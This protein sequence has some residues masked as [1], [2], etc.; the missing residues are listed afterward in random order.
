MIMSS[1]QV[2][3]KVQCSRSVLSIKGVY[4]DPAQKSGRVGRTMS[5]ICIQSDWIKLV[6]QWSVLC[7]ECNGHSHK[8]CPDFFYMRKSVI[9][10]YSMSC[11]S[12]E[13]SIAEWAA[14]CTYT[15]S[16]LWHFLY[17]SPTLNTS[18]TTLVTQ[19]YSSLE[20]HF[21]HVLASH[22]PFP[23]PTRPGPFSY[24]DVDCRESWI[25]TSHILRYMSCHFSTHLF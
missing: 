15:W 24:C 3:L 6:T 13:S 16:A 1:S 12:A 20:T 2:I 25:T 23:S 5:L 8:P 17:S 14:A 11:K 9:E 21:I 10:S 19:I 4:Y 7:L 22:R 18:G